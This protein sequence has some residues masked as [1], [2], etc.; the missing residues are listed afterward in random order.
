[1]CTPPRRPLHVDIEEDVVALRMRLR[2]R[3]AGGPV[4]V[5]MHLR[6]L[7]KGPCRHHRIEV[8]MGDEM[9]VDPVDLPLPHRPG[10]V[11]DRLAQR[12]L[13][14]QQLPG[15]RGFAGA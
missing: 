11:G 5:A 4:A 13:L 1:M 9:V 2:Q 7:G 3:L 8:F 6:P 12:R 15:N 10:G 14:S